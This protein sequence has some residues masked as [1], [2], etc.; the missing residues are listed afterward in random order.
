LRLLL[1]SRTP[2]DRRWP[3]S[4]GSGEVGEEVVESLHWNAAAAA[5]ADGLELALRQQLVELA[6]ADS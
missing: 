4:A 1:V 5:D 2:L 3:G 6:S